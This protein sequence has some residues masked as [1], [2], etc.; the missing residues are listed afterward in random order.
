TAA[1]KILGTFGYM[2]PEQARGAIAELDARSDVY[3]LGAILFEIL[4]LEPLHPKTSWKEML[5]STLK[6]VSARPS[7]RAPHLDVPPE[8]EEICVRATRNDPK[9]R[10]QSARDLHEAVER[11]LDGDRDVEARRKMART[12]ARKAEERASEALRAPGRPGGTAVQREAEDARRTALHEVGRALALDPKNGTAMQV[13]TKLWAAPPQ[14]VP[15]EVAADVAAT[16][17]RRLRF[18]LLQAA[19]FDIASLLVLA[20]IVLLMGPLNVPLLV[21]A[22]LLVI[23]SAA[24]KLLSRRQRD[25]GRGHFFA[26]AGYLFNVL[27]LLCVGRA[28]GPLFF[29]PFLLSVFTIGYCMSPVARYRA[30]ILVTGCVALI[31]SVAVEVLGKHAGIPPSYLFGLDHRSMIIVAQAVEFRYEP[32]MLALGVA[33][34]LM[35]LAPGLMMGRQQDALRDAER[36]SALQTWHLKHLLPDEAQAPVSRSTS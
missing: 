11:Y 24:T 5:F 32:T 27:S 17:S 35:V 34:F 26:Y 18:Q 33:A 25:I 22:S 16:T 4:T 21:A 31:A 8:L 2:P 23:L 12:H 19:Q 30:T 29:T 14:E 7:K 28:F 1:G 13:L 9:H 3:A 36:R 20:P 15:A 10:F 6:G